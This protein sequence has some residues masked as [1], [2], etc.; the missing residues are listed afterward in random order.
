MKKEQ[1]TKYTLVQHSAWTAK[2]D[3]QF[4]RAVE[5]RELSSKGAE[6]RVLQAGGLVFDD[7]GT[8]YEASDNENYQN[9]NRGL[10]PK[11]RGTF[12]PKCKIGGAAV[13]IP[14]PELKK[15]RVTISDTITLAREC[16]MTVMAR[17]VEHAE[18]IGHTAA[19]S[20]VYPKELAVTE[21]AGVQP[22]FALVMDEEQTD[23]TP[24]EVE[25]E[26]AP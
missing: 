9:V 15:F 3:P 10:I 4:A 7:Y 20:F 26:E 23:N 5:E 16:T 2:G 12:H 21:G 19:T 17:D 1:A 14:A 22:G 6:L 8:A 18:E 13:Y 25:A 11:V 24:W